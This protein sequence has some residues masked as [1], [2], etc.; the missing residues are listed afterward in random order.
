MA[1]CT[2][3]L[4]GGGGHCRSCIDLI[5]AAGGFRIAGIIERSDAQAPSSGDV[6]GYEII[7]GDDDL[8]AIRREHAH[9]LVAVGQIRSAEP[10]VRL[11]ER[12]KELGFALPVVVSPLAHVSRHA[13]LGEGTV[14][15][16]GAVVNA[17]AEVGLN[18]II[19]TKALIEHDARIGAHTH[20]ATAAIVNGG[21]SVGARSFVGS[22]ATIVH[23]V[24]LPEAS[25]IRAGQLVTAAVASGDGNAARAR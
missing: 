18:C 25:F 7:G 10:R 2:I 5:E 12:L 4:I 24:R 3:V 20:I 17:A 1:E 23:D 14:V 9:A 13:V 16:H 6:L 19:N 22:N 21:S 8:P 15:M 11:Y